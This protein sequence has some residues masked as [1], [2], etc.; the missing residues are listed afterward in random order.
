[1]NVLPMGVLSLKLTSY[2]LL[3][4]KYSIF[5]DDIVNYTHC[6]DKMKAEELEYK[7]LQYHY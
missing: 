1:M 2:I 4:Y 7:Y 3:L 5:G 6:K